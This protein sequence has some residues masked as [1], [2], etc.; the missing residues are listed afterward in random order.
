ME[1]SSQRSINRYALV[2]QRIA[3]ERL[4]ATEAFNL[5]AWTPNR[6]T[7]PS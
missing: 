2:H 6:R 3:S 4:R 7:K 5:L 1:K